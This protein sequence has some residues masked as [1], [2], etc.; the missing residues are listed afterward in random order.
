MP[1]GGIKQYPWTDMPVPVPGGSGDQGIGGGLESDPGPNGIQQ[2][3]WTDPICPTPGLSPTPN[4]PDLPIG[5]TFS[6]LSDNIAP[7]TSFDPGQAGITPDNT[8][9][10]KVDR[11]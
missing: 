1:G 8:V 6:T 10:R 9:N 3:P 2:S 5:P 4:S 7:G 11:Q